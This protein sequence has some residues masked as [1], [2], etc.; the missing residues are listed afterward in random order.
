MKTYLLTALYFLVVVSLSAD[1]TTPADNKARSRKS[2]ES[3][4]DTMDAQPKLLRIAATVDGSGRII[5]TRQAVRY[6]H[7]HWEGPT[8]MVFDGEPWPNLSRTPAAWRDVADRLDLTKA[9]IVKRKGRDVIA[10]ENTP[11]GF[12]LYLCDS[13]NGT[14]EY[15]VTIA[16]PRRR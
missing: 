5:F 15:E 3:A 14:A 11:D 8:N 10:L 9:W 7:K 16:I 6:V 1:E 12:D 4:D 2:V 13:P